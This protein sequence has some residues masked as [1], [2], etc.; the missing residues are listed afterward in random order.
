MDGKSGQKLWEFQA[1]NHMY[2][3][4]SAGDLDGDQTP[5]LTI[6]SYDGK[7]YALRAR[8]GK[9]LWEVAPG[10][11]YF[12]SP[13]VI[14]DLDGD[15]RPEVIAASQSI[16]AIKGNGKIL[17]SVDAK[18]AARGRWGSI[19]RGVSIADMDGDGKLDVV[20]LYGSGILRVL[21]GKDGK[22]LYEFDASTLTKQSLS[23]SSHGPVI[24]DLNGDGR[25]DVFFV[26]GATRPKS[27]GLAVALTGFRGKGR[28]WY[29]LRH[30]ARNTGN[31]LSELSP[32]LEA[33]L[34]KT[35]RRKR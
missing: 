12:M 31:I 35:P 23:G 11:R 15:R 34:P 30:D 1:G 24:A 20:A 6:A 3:G 10:D 14:A 22:V 21:R 8:D 18:G 4:C 26:V 29:M 17:W 28:G 7:V 19:T 33:H 2:H 25:L 27:H 5:E 32:A 16:T 13:T 9:K